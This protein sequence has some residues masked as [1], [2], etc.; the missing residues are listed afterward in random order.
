MGEITLHILTSNGIVMWRLQSIYSSKS[1]RSTSR[2]QQHPLADRIDIVSRVGRV[3]MSEPPPQTR[4]P[5]FDC[6]TFSEPLRKRS[7]RNVLWE[8]LW[9]EYEQAT[10]FQSFP[11]L[12]PRERGAHILL[13]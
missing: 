7:V 12:R 13:D 1:P 11:Q 8:T 4:L 3:N 5:L 10:L 6:E 9:K 2:H